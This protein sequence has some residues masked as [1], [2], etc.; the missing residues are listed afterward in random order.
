ML[1]RNKLLSKEIFAVRRECVYEHALLKADAAVK[2]VRSDIVA[3]ACFEHSFLAAD[4]ELELTACHVCSLAVIV[5]MH[6]AHRTFFKM[7]FHNHQLSVIAHYLSF[8]S[9]T[10]VLPFQFF[11][12]LVSFT[13]CFHNS[14]FLKF[15]SC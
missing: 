5:L 8:D 7:Y 11:L 12:E 9:W 4:F 1:Y 13:S 14:L 2:F 3:V 15:I 6:S 10:W